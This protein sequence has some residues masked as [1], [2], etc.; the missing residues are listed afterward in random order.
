MRRVLLFLLLLSGNVFAQTSDRIQLRSVRTLTGDEQPLVVVD[1]IPCDSVRLNHI[2]P[3]LISDITILKDPAA[4]AIYGNRGCNGVVIISTKPHILIR[5]KMDSSLIA[6][7][8]ISILPNKY[9]SDTL[10]LTSDKDGIVVLDKLK[11]KT[12]Y[13]VIASCVGY[14]SKKVLLPVHDSNKD[15]IELEKDYKALD[16]VVIKSGC[17]PRTIICRFGSYGDGIKCGRGSKVVIEQTEE[18]NAAT[19]LKSFGLYP[20]PSSISGTI[21]LQLPRIMEGKIEIITS[22][23]Q[24]VQSSLFKEVSKSSIHLNL[25]S[26]GI[27][28]VRV[29]ENK[30]NLSFTQKLIV[31]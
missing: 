31:Q 2:A 28:F 3:Q 11:S 27:Y 26:A 9:F 20:N 14:K 16:T 29:T 17:L 30:T 12:F 6:A 15:S 19:A 10:V 8:T 18:E 1:G 22:S 7:A 5:D 21:T 24:I 13:E 4:S 23:G 25:T